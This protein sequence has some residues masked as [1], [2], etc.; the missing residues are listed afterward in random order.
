MNLL[1]GS[2][3]VA[4]AVRQVCPD[5]VVA[6]P[7]SPIA[8]VVGQLAS[9]I[10]NGDID[11]E[12]INV[13]SSQSA[14]SASIG[15][16]SAGGRVFTTTASQ[17]L[18]AMHEGLFIASSLRL[19]V[20]AAVANR[21]LAAPVSLHADHTDSLAQ[22][23]CGWIQIY[24]EHPQEA[25]DNLVQAY[26]IAEHPDVRTPVLVCMDSFIT[27]H[28]RENV[29]IEDQKDIEEFVGKYRPAFSLLDGEHPVTVGSRAMPDYYF[30]HKINQAQGL[31][32]AGPVIKD[33]GKEFGGLFGRYYGFFESY[34]M[35]DA[36]TAIVIMSSAAGTVK[37]IVEKLRNAGEKVGVLKLRVFR[38]FPYQ[39][40]REALAQVR[41]AAVLERAFNPGIPGGPLFHEIRSALYDLPVR[42]QVLPYVYGL[43]GRDISGEHVENVFLRLKEINEKETEQEK[44]L[45][46]H[47][48]KYINLRE[49]EQEKE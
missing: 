49:K 40:I 37:E 6:H 44:P 19:P 23:D 33:T 3:A 26:K 4:E 46:F 43:G 35:E 34:R 17:G 20:V 28:T 39:E 10:A 42:P 2:T 21:A 48:V 15:A 38:P 27:S 24:C 9:Y 32:N 12:Y 14:L 30:E 36:E 13:E 8:S 47:N 11:T 7:I 25:Y 1:D 22:R 16:S 41:A 29:F 18:A 5:L 45:T 31:I